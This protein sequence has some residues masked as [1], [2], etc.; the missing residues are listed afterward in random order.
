MAVGSQNSG[1]QRPTQQSSAQRTGPEET[2][3][4]PEE[5]SAIKDDVGQIAGAAVEQGRH[6]LDSAKEQA[7]TY[8]DKRKDDA[9]QSVADLA[10][11][12]RDAMSQFDERP[13]IR[14][15][16]DSAA[17]GLEQLAETIRARSFNE[18]F[19]DVEAVVRRRPATVAAATMAAG[20]L[21]ARFI[22][23]SAE[24]IRAAEQQRRTSGTRRPSSDQRSRAQASS[25]SSYARGGA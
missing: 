3:Q 1:Q 23:S 2:S 15:F 24:G 10:Q 20:F 14:A 17:G 5:W 12:L 13:N 8:V 6:F 11:S 9:A 18:I 25:G 4:G 22:K 7:T 19:D 16:V 21:V